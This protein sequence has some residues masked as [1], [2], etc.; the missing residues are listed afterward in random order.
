MPL[1]E[2]SLLAGRSAEQKR[3]M[4]RA[5][6]V[7]MVDHGGARPENVQVIFRDVAQEDWL[8][9]SNEPA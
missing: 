4:A 7:A 3:R 8:S 2:V 6:Q 1:V 9:G 5:I